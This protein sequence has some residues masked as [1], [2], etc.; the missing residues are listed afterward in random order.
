MS[1]AQLMLLQQPR[2]HREAEA[3]A[4][5]LQACGFTVSAAITDPR[6]GD[7]LVVWNRM[8][9]HH[10][11]ARRFE[12]AGAQVLVTENGYLGADWRGSRWFAL[13]HNHHNGRGRWPDGGA[14][15]WDGWGVDLAPMRTMG[16]EGVVL[17]QRGIGEQ[18]LRAPD[19]WA[20]QVAR[21]RG[22]RIRR[23]P[24]TGPCVP[25]DEDLAHASVVATWSSG[26]AIRALLMGVHV[27]YGMPG[28]I[29]ASAATPFGQKLDASDRRLAMFR[30]L[31][32]AMWREG[33]IAS[34]EAFR[35]V[36]AC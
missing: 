12:A 21:Q 29:A 33:E 20:A 14:E 16:G 34:G 1:R 23:H 6:P 18:D 8:G 7:V 11:Q 36:L 10:V 30:R 9:A 22:M 31:A 27:L 2:K 32:W 15:R 28:W 13:A 26:A 24:G 19:G 3:F 25:L 5:G 35:M 4:A 17:A